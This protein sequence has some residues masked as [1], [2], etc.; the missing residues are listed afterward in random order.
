MKKLRW[1]NRIR[2]ACVLGVGMC[3]GAQ[4]FAATPPLPSIDSAMVAAARWVA[5]ADAG[6]SG[7]MWNTSSPF[8]Q[9]SIPRDG[10]AKYLGNLHAQMGAATDREWNQVIRVDNP[11]SL[12][13]GE[14]LNVVFI[15]HFARGLAIEKVSLSPNGSGWTPV[16][17]VVNPV[18]QGAQPASTTSPPSK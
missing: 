7:T 1:V 2:V 3:G 15:T 5:L 4:G 8:M 14:Y 6:D 16:G 18:R 13:S 10:W 12:P 17:Y 11:P 9:S